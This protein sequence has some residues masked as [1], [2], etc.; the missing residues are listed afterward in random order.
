[1]IS[2][3][4]LAPYVSFVLFFSFLFFFPLEGLEQAL[5]CMDSESTSQPKVADLS[6]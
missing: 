2:Q 1:M 6:G 3:Y 5:L 4:S